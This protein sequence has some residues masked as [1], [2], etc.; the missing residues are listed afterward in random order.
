MG[1]QYSKEEQL[2]RERKRVGAYGITAYDYD[3]SSK[4]FAFSSGFS[5]FT[6][7][8]ADNRI[9]ETSVGKISNYPYCQR[10]SQTSA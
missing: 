9:G 3:A 10:T 6:V 5:V 4:T 1:T 2:L 8:D 7:T